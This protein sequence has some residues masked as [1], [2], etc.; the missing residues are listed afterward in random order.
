MHCGVN[1]GG[2]GQSSVCTALRSLSYGGGAQKDQEASGPEGKGRKCLQR[3][4][5]PQL[6]TGEIGQGQK[7]SFLAKL[8]HL[9]AILVRPVSGKPRCTVPLGAEGERG[10]RGCRGGS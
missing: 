3:R 1:I 9:K 7:D 4:Q 5:C 10:V 8:A 6:L 2:G